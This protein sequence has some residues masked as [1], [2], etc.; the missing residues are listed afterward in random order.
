MK[1]FIDSFD[2]E[3][4]L[5]MNEQVATNYA[6]TLKLAVEEVKQFKKA[7]SDKSVS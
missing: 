1:Q 3:T 5:T 6:E 2:F 7:N 4:V